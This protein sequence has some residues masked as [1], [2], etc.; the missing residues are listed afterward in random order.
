M[1]VLEHLLEPEFDD[2]EAVSARALANAQLGTADFLQQLGSPE[3]LLDPTEK[4]AARVAF[5]AT[6]AAAPTP[7]DDAAAKS[8][9]LN[10][11]VPAAVQHLHA[12]LGSYDWEYVE[13]ARELRGY[14]VARLLEESQDRTNKAASRIRAIE[15]LGKL[16][17]V[18][19]FTERVHVT[20]EVHTQ[21][22]LANKIRERLLRLQ[23]RANP[24]SAEPPID[25]PPA[26]PFEPPTPPT[27]S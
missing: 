22:E 13:K 17:E 27:T 5:L 26:A 6:A 10:L 21:D 8:A 20:K 2:I 15:L 19:S 7:Q 16:T 12:M 25:V 14:V 23:A 4:Q 18:A 3:H 24:T 1:R 9:L 11:K